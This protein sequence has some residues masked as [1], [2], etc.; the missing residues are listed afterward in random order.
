[1]AHNGV[2]FLD[3]LPE[4]DRGT[5][6]SLRQPLEDG[7]VA[8]SRVG[9]AAVFPSRFQLIGGHEPVPVRALQA[10][11]TAD[12]TAGRLSWSGTS[13]RI[14]GPLRDRIDMWVHMPRVRPE[15]YVGAAAPE[16]SRVV[17]DRIAAARAVQLARRRRAELGAERP[18]PARRLRPGSRGAEHTRSG[19]PSSR[20][21]APGAWSVFCELPVLPPIWRDRRASK[22]RISTRRHG[23]GRR[24]GAG[25]SRGWCDRCSACRRWGRS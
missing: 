14:S 6:E 9:R 17:A 22:Q 3:E 20:A 7:R 24:L 12:A 1:M 19:W 16:D 13:D 10:R 2:L 25:D 21:G 11:A 5:L 8:I 18:S 23:I 15:E 4:F